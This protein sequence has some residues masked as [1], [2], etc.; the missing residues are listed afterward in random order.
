MS[1]DLTNVISLPQQLFPPLIHL[2]RKYSFI[3][4]VFI[5][6][7]EPEIHLFHSFDNTHRSTGKLEKLMQLIC[8]EK[9]LNTEV[10]LNQI[11]L[12][13]CNFQLALFLV[14]S[15]PRPQTLEAFWDTNCLPLVS[16]VLSILLLPVQDL[17]IPS[18]RILFVWPQ[19]LFL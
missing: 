19:C 9:L 6:N 11:F 17:L 2:K 15:T 4:I 13:T 16:L 12:L 18:Y 14:T 1:N 5:F 10:S 7:F 3:R 8:A